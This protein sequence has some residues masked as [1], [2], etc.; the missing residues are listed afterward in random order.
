M[1]TIQDIFKRTGKQAT[2]KEVGITGTVGGMKQMIMDA[3]KKRKKAMPITAPKTLPTFPRAKEPLSP[4][5]RGAW[6]KKAKE[7]KDIMKNRKWTY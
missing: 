1:P 5:L 7:M 6:E 2:P 4:G 3:L